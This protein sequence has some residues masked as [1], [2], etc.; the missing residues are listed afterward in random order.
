MPGLNWT[1]PQT[2]E[3]DTM[4]VD[5]LTTGPAGTP[6]RTGES[7]LSPW[8][9]DQAAYPVLADGGHDR[10]T[11]L[12]PDGTTWELDADEFAEVVAADL[13]R[14]PLPERAPIVLAVPSAG[15]RYLDLPRKLAERTGRTV[16]V[17]TGL[18]QRNPDPAATS[19][20]GVLHRDGLPDGTWLPVRPGLAPDPDDDAPAWHREVLTQPIVSSHTGEQ[21]G[22]SFHHPAEL[23]GPRETYGD[24]DRMSF[25][26]HW[27]A[28]TNAYS[29]KLPMR[30]PGPADKAYR[31]AGHG[32]PGGLSLPLA[33]GSDR[34][35][36]KHEAAGWL[37]RRKSLSSLP[38]DHW[39][40][41]V[42]CHS[43]APAQGAAQDVAQ[44]SGPLPVPFTADPL[45]DDALS[46]G[47]HLANQ[48]RR[49]TRL[50]YSS[51]GVNRFG[52]GPMR[53]L[54]TD[55]QGR[56]WWWETSHPEPDEAELDRLAARMEPGVTPSPRTRAEVLRAV[57]ALKAV[58]GPDV[59]LDAAFPDLVAGAVA[60]AGMW[61]ADPDLGRTGPLWPQSLSQV[62]A[63]HPLATGTTDLAV[64]RQVLAE[65]ARAWRDSGNTLSVSGFVAL[66][67]LRTAA[68]WLSD[69]AAVDGAAV[70][71]LGLTD[72]A[73][74]PAHR[75]RMFW[76]RVRAEE[77]LLGPAADALT[78]RA[79]RLDPDTAP[80]DAGRAAA[81]DLLTRGFAAGRNMTDPEVTGAYA[82]EAA[83]ALAAPVLLTLAGTA[84]GSGRDW[85]DKPTLLPRLDA[86]RV[87]DTTVDAPWAG[88]DAG[89]QSLPVPYA[90]RASVDLEDSSHVQL[91]TGG[92]SHRLSAAEFAE[93]LAVDTALA[94][95]AATTP[96]LLLLDGLSGPDPVLAETVARRL[97]RPVWWSTSPVELSA[98]DAA[99]G[100]LP[101]LAPDLSTLSQPTA[102]DWRHTTPATGPATAP[103]VG[104]PQVPAT[105]A[106][107]PGAATPAVN[108]G[109]TAE[110][111]PSQGPALQ[112]P[113]LQGPAP[114][115]A[116]A[117]A[118]GPET[119]APA[120]YA[121]T[122]TA[123]TETSEL[124]TADTA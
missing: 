113:A 95:V 115:P 120:E 123:G 3:T 77:T 58:M 76:A 2:A 28:A 9:W 6:V 101:V 94:A 91:T 107:G 62:V 96:V 99:E 118:V 42:I 59:V 16:W 103:A 34:A 40:D 47:Q 36:D 86:F 71:A 85:R 104:G 45:G 80:D 51:Q 1:G 20:I 8:P 66:P 60:V 88:V 122:D 69:P 109:S 114:A 17:H 48:L 108:N 78:V 12:L 121:G 18:A 43:G 93:L 4:F 14:H 37:R 82:V 84:F 116:E 68:D 53:V 15:D 65:A 55:A 100:E 89:G 23:V 64:T 61:A 21:I 38:K 87:A 33:D 63:A 70:L 83:G 22:R 117:K 5:R 31:L 27:D 32:L 90:V 106:P 24:L 72:P 54:A 46:L 67:G 97:G 56:P 102:T 112:G 124:E 13:T 35:V 10:V 25:Y 49:T 111:H 26:V 98:P 92:T 110:P 73:D 29:G 57:R 30:D 81:R 52:D 39:V 7:T 119:A 74:A 19:T 41:L 79:L 44:L 11:A 75:T 50:S 105:P